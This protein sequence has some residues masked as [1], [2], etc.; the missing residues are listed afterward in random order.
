MSNIEII[1]EFERLVNFIQLQIDE[2]KQE[3]DAKKATA[4]T[5]RLKQIKNALLTIKN[6]PNKLSND[7]LDDFK[8][9]PGIGKGKLDRIKEIFKNGKL[10]EL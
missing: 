10:D 5:F 9:Y 6:Y 4:N 2:A 7:N 3:H 1:N 8:E